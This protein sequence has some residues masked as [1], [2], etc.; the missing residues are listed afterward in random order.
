MKSST[1]S[2][3]AVAALTAAALGL[4]GPVAAA[5]LVP[6]PLDPATEPMPGDDGSVVEGD[7]AM[8]MAM[9]IMGEC[10]YGGDVTGIPQVNR[11]DR[12]YQFVC[13]R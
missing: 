7:D 3:I 2:A 4:A 13:M 5:P 10:M 1:L 9:R 11:M 8:V 12:G 6:F